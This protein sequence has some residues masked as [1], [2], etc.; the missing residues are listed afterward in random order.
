MEGGAA[1]IDGR[2]EVGDKLVAVSFI[3]Y[4]FMLQE[5]CVLIFFITDKKS[6]LIC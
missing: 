6:L 5:C 4:I 3:N 2:L 1:H